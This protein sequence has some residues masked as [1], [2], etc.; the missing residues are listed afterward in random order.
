MVSASPASPDPDPETFSIDAA[1]PSVPGV[2]QSDLLNPGMTVQVPKANLGLAAGDELDAVSTAVDAVQDNNIVYFSVD[3]SSSGIAG[4]LTPLDVKGQALLNQQAGDIYATTDA[5]GVASVPQGINSLH[6]NQNF[7][8]EVPVTTALVDNTGKPQDNLDALS[9]EEFDLTGD[10]WQDRPVYF[11][12]A[13]ASPS[14]GGVF[15]AADI[16]VSP[17]GGG[18]I[19][20][21][22]AAANMGLDPTADDLDALA[23]L[24]LDKNGVASAGDM[25]LFSLAPGS[26]TL[27]NLGASP[28]DVFLTTFNNTS[29]VRYNAASLGLL[30]QDNVDALEVQVPE[31][32]TV[33][34]VL[35]GAALVVGRKRKK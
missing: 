35:L 18:P 16:L 5:Q 8:G 34:V 29:F 25:G 30:S 14:L 3:R 13:S 15:S 23:L 31:P 20:V 1:S 9:F 4:P 12:L 11:S 17:S 2:D 7:L 21:F 10:S 19:G 6:Q 27:V 24:D 26:Q 22:A 32:A 28:A 33:T